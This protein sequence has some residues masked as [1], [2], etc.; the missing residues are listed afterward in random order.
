MATMRKADGPRRAL[1][2]H[3]R[4]Q[5]YEAVVV[6]AG[7]AGVTCMGNLLERRVGPILW[8]DDGFD[9]GRVNR[10]YREVPSNTKVKLFI[11]FATAVQPFRKIVSGQSSRGRWDEPED[12]ETVDCAKPDK[13]QHMRVLEQEKGCSLSHA[14]DMMLMLTDGLRRMPGV[15]SHVGRMSEAILD[16]RSSQWSV[17]IE[18]RDSSSPVTA[19]RLVLCTGASPK[20][21]ALPI[22]IP[23][24]ESL[25]LDT[26]LS[27]SRLHHALS[28]LG[29]PTGPKTVAVV[30][31]SH[32]AILVLMNLCKLASTV[33]PDLRVRWFTRHPLRYA[34]YMDGWILRDNTGLKGEAAAWAK[35]NLEPEIFANS[36]V[37]KYIEP[38]SYE[39]GAEAE[40]FAE[41]MSDC[42]YYIQAI[43]YERDPLPSLRTSSGKEIAP[44][45]NHE[46]GDFSYNPTGD[47]TDAS[48]KKLPG[49]Y[50]AGIAFPE[51][52]RDPHGNVEMAVGM[53]KFMKY[54]KRVS[55]SWN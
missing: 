3:A 35:A 23:D 52:V 10:Y 11:D 41:H 16:E 8:V 53:F 9:G 40:T 27:P 21:P 7:P 25:D 30:G 49:V 42:D 39:A 37:S 48:A 24:I 14:A 47:D 17:R 31:A 4:P 22:S 36:D 29:P 44:M 19:K 45:Y 13:L 12:H 43:G 5:H 33:K 2:T 51:R 38:I 15:V 34:V 6:G 28:P 1:A 46:T 20:Q 26:V 18:G 54:V 32:S 55:P 50:G